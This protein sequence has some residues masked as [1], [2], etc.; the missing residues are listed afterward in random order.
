MAAS[1]DSV[2]GLTPPLR[3]WPHSV[4]SGDVSHNLGGLFVA[5]A[6][7]SGGASPSPPSL[8][9]V[10]GQFYWQAKPVAKSRFDGVLDS[11]IIRTSPSPVTAEGAKSRPPGVLSFNLGAGKRPG[12]LG[13]RKSSEKHESCFLPHQKI[14]FLAGVIAL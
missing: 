3:L 5:G 11:R 6:S 9:A 7:G 13:K 12:P 10:G 8:W 4:A 2:N 14:L 1:A